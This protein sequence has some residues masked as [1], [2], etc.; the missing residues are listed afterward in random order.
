MDLEG[1]VMVV[2]ED[3]SVKVKD[4]SVSYGKTEVVR[5]LNLEVHGSELVA[6]VG[7]SGCGKSTL[8]NAIAGFIPFSGHVYRPQSIGVVFQEDSLFPWL[9]VAQNIAF[10]LPDSKYFNYLCNKEKKKIV[11]DY[12]RLIGLEDHANKYP[13]E[14]SGGQKQRV[15]VARALAPNTSLVLMDEP[16]GSLDIYTRDSMQTWLLDLLVR[17]KRTIL[18]V[19]HSIEEAI[20]MSDRI[21]VL[22]E[23]E[24]KREYK[25]DFD[26]PRKEDTK[27]SQKFLDLKK[28]IDSYLKTGQDQKN[29]NGNYA[30]RLETSLPVHLLRNFQKPFSFHFRFQHIFSR[31]LA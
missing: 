25:V 7:K 30:P 20:Y 31:I 3:Q 22:D 15:A 13:N 10:G 2:I 29:A 17:E 26:R 18:F 14:L 8:L 21:L 9:T 16:F 23:G 24:I 1:L 12:L 5:N 6:I 28:R 11:A 19:T 4:L 27:Y